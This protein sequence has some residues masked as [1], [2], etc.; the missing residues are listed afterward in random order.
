MKIIYYFK[1]NPNTSKWSTR[2]IKSNKGSFSL[3]S[4]REINKEKKEEKEK[5]DSK[6][7]EEEEEK[8][9]KDINKLLAKKN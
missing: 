7:D 3:N 5:E 9:E 6:D 4:K 1:S 8:E 2:R